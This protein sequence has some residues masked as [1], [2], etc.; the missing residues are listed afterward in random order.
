MSNW[1]K[2]LKNL[3]GKRLERKIVVIESDDW[4]GIRMPS[5]KVFD[6]LLSQGVR[7]DKCHFNRFDSLENENDLSALG[8][9]LASVSD[10]NGNP[11]IITANYNVANPNFEEIR[12]S[13]FQTYSFET[14]T[15]TYKR[16]YPNENIVGLTNELKTKK[17]IYPQLHGREHL[18]P[19]LWLQLLREG[20]SDLLKAFELGS[21][22]LSF[23]TS[24]SINIPYLAALLYKNKQ[25]KL[26]VESSI[27]E[28][29]SLFEKAWGYR[30]KTFI[31]PLYYWH[32]D[33]ESTFQK[34]GIEFLQGGDRQTQ[35]DQK[36]KRIFHKLGQKN[37]LG[38]TYLVRNV[39]FELSGY[40]KE[41]VLENALND[42]GISFAMRK[43]A[44]ICSHR[45]NFMGGIVEENRK[46]NLTYL[47]RL[48]EAIVKK[49]PEVEFMNSEELG[50]I[51][52]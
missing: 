27:L 24:P 30:S 18:N 26:N 8:E 51:V 3:P 50:K 31:A 10:K 17:L 9:V 2:Y 22:G 7:V 48:L 5:K 25:Q 37:A 12:K 41:K 28:G 6:S 20:N 32:S 16:F 11:A 42:I 40:N 29:A 13:A 1:R 45:V 33:L 47:K 39:S 23:N 38:Q 43:P 46:E 21:Y 36:N 52:S 15:E 44:V 14:F 35:F 34:A 19:D 4:G 49:W